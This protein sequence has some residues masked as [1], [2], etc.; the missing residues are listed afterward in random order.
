M[1]SGFG[2][3][4]FAIFCERHA[5]ISVGNDL[6]EG[7]QKRD[8][9][10]SA[11]MAKFSGMKP[12]HPTGLEIRFEREM[13]TAVAGW[14]SEITRL[15]PLVEPR[16]PRPAPRRKFPRHRPHPRKAAGVRKTQEA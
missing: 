8:G 12:E 7:I 5:P 3:A 11:E 9:L 13:A 2:F 10:P 4:A 16:P 15:D 6:W 1:E 14:Q